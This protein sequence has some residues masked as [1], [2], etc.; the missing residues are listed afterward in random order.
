MFDGKLILFSTVIGLLSKVIVY[1]GFLGQATS[2]IMKV[3]RKFLIAWQKVFSNTFCNIIIFWLTTILQH[4][5]IYADTGKN[6]IF[7]GFLS[8]TCIY[9]LKASRDQYYITNFWK[10]FPICKCWRKNL[11]KRNK[12]DRR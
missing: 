7:C 5:T 3:A 11:P 4:G 10:C 8:F 2:N 1:F 9:I 6:Y 12:Y